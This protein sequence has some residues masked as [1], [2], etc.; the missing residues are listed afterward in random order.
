MEQEDADDEGVGDA[1]N[2]EEESDQDEH[3]E[4]LQ[5]SRVEL[6]ALV[7]DGWTTTAGN[8][9]WKVI[10]QSEVD[11]L[12]EY[13]KVGVHSFNFN[14][15]SELDKCLKDPGKQLGKQ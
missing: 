7:D 1:N 14:E 9:V 11:L 2:N 8:I 13:A 4:K 12:Q 6:Q 3:A 10:E 5:R 15:F